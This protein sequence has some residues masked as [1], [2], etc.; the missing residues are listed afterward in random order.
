[1]WNRKILKEEAKKVFTFNKKN[2]WQM[3]LVGLIIALLSG[4]LGSSASSGFSSLASAFSNNLER[5]PVA[6]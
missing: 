3:V 2:Y 4:G 5:I 1:M 6:P